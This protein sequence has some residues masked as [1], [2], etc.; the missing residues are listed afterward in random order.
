MDSFFDVYYNVQLMDNQVYLDQPFEEGWCAEEEIC[1]TD[2][3]FVLQ[4]HFSTLL[5]RVLKWF[6]RG[7]GNDDRQGCETK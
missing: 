1:L 2:V 7:R 4:Y 3:T 6:I 5:T